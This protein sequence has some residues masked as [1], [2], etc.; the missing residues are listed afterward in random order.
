MIRV[1]DGLS[2][3][4][5]CEVSIRPSWTVK[6]LK[7]AIAEATSVHKREQRLLWAGRSIRGSQSLKKI[8]EGEAAVRLVRVHPSW[9]VHLD[10][11]AETGLLLGLE[12]NFKKEQE[13]QQALAHFFHDRGFV[14]AAVQENGGVIH[15][16]AQEFSQDREV[17]MAALRDNGTALA[18]TS[19]MM[20][21][22][23][24]VVLTA[25]RQNGI[26]LQYASEEL[27][28][29]REV[30]ESAVGETGE[31][32]QYAAEEL[33][34]DREIALNAVR[35][36]ATALPLVPLWFQNKRDFILDAVKANGDALRFV[37]SLELSKDHEIVEAADAYWRGLHGE[38]EI[39]TS[40]RRADLFLRPAHRASA[41][42]YEKLMSG[43]RGG[44]L[45]VRPHP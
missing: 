1:I 11:I 8:A 27:R 41:R 37:Q 30:V 19:E 20:S 31:A 4:L 38:V 22:D 21:N 18:F 42:N 36:S 39:A 14:L 34:L 24:E 13:A 16:A 3:E 6:D 28:Q 45:G 15:H 7:A 26:A 5:L 10:S 23:R 33:R 43:N 12:D 2:E 25:V 44:A 35:R 9:H 32:I 40:P 17:V 29:D